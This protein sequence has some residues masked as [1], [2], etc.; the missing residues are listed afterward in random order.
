MGNTL[1]E[2]ND[3]A[4]A[5]SS[6]KKAVKVNPSFADGHCNLA[7]I[8]KDMGNISE[9]IQS[10]ENAL[11]L[12][13]VF[14]DAYCNLTHC[15][16]VICDWDN[17]EERMQNIVS[18]LKKQ[19]IFEKLP[20]IHPHHS[21][22]YP[23][24]NEERKEIASRHA[25]LYLEKINMLSHVD[26]RHNREVNGRLRIGY[27]SSDFGNHPTSHLMQSLPGLHN[28]SRVEIF[29]YALNPDDGTNFRSKIVKESEHFCDLS[30]V[31]C[32]IKAAKTIHDDGINIL[33]NMN[34]YT[35]GAKNEIFALRPAPLQVMW[36]GY[37][38]TSGADFMDYIITD[39]ISS[40][41]AHEWDY[42][43]KFAYMPETYFIG[44][45][46]QMFMHLKNKFIVRFSHKASS[47]DVA[48]VNSGDNIKL[49]DY[50]TVKKKAYIIECDTETQ[51]IE[52]IK[53]EINIP[54]RIA[55]VAIDPRQTTVPFL[56]LIAFFIN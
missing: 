5:L 31:P 37:P 17:Y 14:P 23:L 25:N 16:Q 19:L 52:I 42:S 47:S 54:D 46:K 49:E 22:L 48:I 12:N 11:K 39:P 3:V 45:H 32:V 9:A 41:L 13:P 28:R 27:V 51:S 26:F 4:G 20:S 56:L 40:P 34:G 18:V 10:Y 24:S 30:Q 50:I 29:C 1:R 36:L 2:M 21:M 15:L 8:Y 38:G 43:E 6:F 35:K 44:D 33:I 55:T 53:K 7:S